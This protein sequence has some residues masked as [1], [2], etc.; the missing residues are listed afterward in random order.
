MGIFPPLRWHWVVVN[1]K[2]SFAVNSSRPR[3]SFLLC[4]F[5]SKEHQKNLWEDSRR[6]LCPRSLER[7][8]PQTSQKELRRTYL[9]RCKKETKN[10]SS[11]Y[12]VVSVHPGGDPRI[13]VWVSITHSPQVKTHPQLSKTLPESRKVK[14]YNWPSPDPSPPLSSSP[15][16]HRH[17]VTGDAKR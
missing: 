11:C 12:P 7:N 9:S 5:M 14:E 3:N 15:D 10:H 4:Y 8:S 1:G 16:I 13:L 2:G 6:C 17:T